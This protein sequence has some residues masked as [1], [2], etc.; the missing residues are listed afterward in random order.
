MN[1][2]LRLPM[3][4]V[5]T[6]A[7][8][9]A[10]VFTGLA[11]SAATPAYAT[12]TSTPHCKDSQIR[13]TLERL[14]TAR[15]SEYS[16]NAWVI[17]MNFGSR[18]NLRIVDIGV[19]ALSG[20]TV[21]TASATPTSFVVGSILLHSGQSARAQAAVLRTGG[22]AF[23]EGCEPKVANTLEVLPLYRGWREKSFH[24]SPTALVCTGGDINLAGN[25]LSKTP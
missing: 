21:L 22:S 14:K 17:F 19:E 3:R 23:G 15:N 20:S 4:I 24:L 1:V 11:V 9:T 16:Y 13:E 10:S 7:L 25:Y 5:A 2:R 8:A 12:S 6:F 18:C